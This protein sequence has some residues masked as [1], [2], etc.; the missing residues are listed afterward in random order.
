MSFCIDDLHTDDPT[1]ATLVRDYYPLQGSV[2]SLVDLL[3][4]NGPTIYRAVVELAMGLG[5]Q[6]ARNKYRLD[7]VDMRRADVVAKT[8]ALMHDAITGLW[9]GQV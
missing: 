2:D 1:P 4:T 3:R 8:E 7:E 5:I 9:R 6:A